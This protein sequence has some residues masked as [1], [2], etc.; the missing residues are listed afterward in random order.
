MELVY[1]HHSPVPGRIV[2]VDFAQRNFDSPGSKGAKATKD[3]GQQ[4]AKQKARVL[5]VLVRLWLYCFLRNHTNENFFYMRGYM[6]IIDDMNGRGLGASDVFVTLL[7]QNRDLVR[8]VKP[9]TVTRFLKFIR[10]LGPLDTWLHFL[11]ALCDPQNGGALSDKQQ[12]VLSKIAFPGLLAPQQEKTAVERNRE[13]LMIA[14]ALEGPIG[15]PLA[16]LGQVDPKDCLGT[17][18]LTHG[19]HDVAIA[20]T[21]P[22]AWEVGKV[23]YHGP[24]QLN[25]PILRTSRGRKWV[26]LAQV[27]WVLQPKELCQEVTG[28]SWTTVLQTEAKA[29]S[30]DWQHAGLTGKPHKSRDAG[31]PFDVSRIDLLRMLARY[32][33]AQLQLVASLA[34]DRQMNSIMALQ[35]EYSYKVCLSGAADTRLPSSIRASFFDLLMALWVDRHPH[36]QVV[37]SDPELYGLQGQSPGPRQFKRDV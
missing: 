23:L 15:K 18:L 1:R 25:L 31:N 37:V 12:L 35:E 27:V 19:I 29:V 4:V 17:P 32:C 13:E 6:D 2:S 21:H 9:E 30:S 3:D 10:I 22:V 20:W 28:Q 7:S 14:L 36:Y 8:K 26:S 5:K 11:K 33:Q 24:E 16:R 34:K